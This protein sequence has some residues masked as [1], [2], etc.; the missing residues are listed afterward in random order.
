MK[1]NKFILAVIFLSIGATAWFYRFLPDQIALHYDYK[2]DVDNW[3][4]RNFIWMTSSLP[5]IIYIL[6]AVVPKIDPRKDSY[7]KHMKG[8]SILANGLALFMIALNWFTIFYSMGYDLNIQIFIMTAL[9]ILF[10]LLGNY[11]PNARQN[12][13]F[14]F[15]T[16][17]TL[18]DDTS[19]RKTHRMGGF[20]FVGLGIV[21][22]VGAFI[23]GIAA[24]ILFFSALVLMILGLF[25]YSYLIFRKTGS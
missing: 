17:W 3:G 2:G 24:L 10:I 14:G 12:Y 19:W 5:L 16:P 4:S 20:A 21:A 15:K 13:T 8:Y 6:M 25:V 22:L 11:L 18:A 23:P 9:G 1:I 7:E